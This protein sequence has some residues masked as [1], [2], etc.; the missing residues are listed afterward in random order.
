MLEDINEKFHSVIDEADKI[1]NFNDM[2][3][4]DR[5]DVYSE[6]IQRAI[7]NA[8][9]VTADKVQKIQE[10]CAAGTAATRVAIT[11]AIATLR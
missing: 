7:S 8:Y 6:E 11:A 2:L 5:L 3:G 1:E 4:N 9:N 10:A